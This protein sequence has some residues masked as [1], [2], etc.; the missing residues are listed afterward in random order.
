MGRELMRFYV[1]RKVTSTTI[2]Y[3]DYLLTLDAEVNLIW[4]APWNLVKVLYLIMRYMPFMDVTMI[5]YYTVTPGVSTSACVTT[6][7]IAPASIVIGVIIAET[8]LAIRTWTLWR[9]NLIIAVI[10]AA[11]GAGCFIPTLVIVISYIH[12][13]HHIETPNPMLFPC[14]TTKKPSLSII[15]ALFLAFEVVILV[16]TAIAGISAYRQSKSPFVK[17]VTQDGIMYYVYLGALSIGNIVMIVVA[18]IYILIL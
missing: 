3:F 4:K 12:S 15:Y 14:I 8:L 10:F 5:L 1:V 11:I 9:K 13:V 6:G 7:R 16:F 18:R 17:M 2:L